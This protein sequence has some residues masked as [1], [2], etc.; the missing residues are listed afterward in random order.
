QTYVPNLN[1]NLI[2]I[3]DVAEGKLTQG[4]TKISR[5]NRSRMIEISG[6]LAPDGAIGNIRNDAEKILASEKMPPGMTY[7][8]LGQ[9]EDFNDLQQNVM[10]AIALAIIFV[11]LI[12][13]S[14][15]ES[16]V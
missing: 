15:Y 1:N 10:I 13:S 14:L 11:F 16:F 4:P 6:D 3:S 12:L 7:S 5:F 9:S 8:F 2:K